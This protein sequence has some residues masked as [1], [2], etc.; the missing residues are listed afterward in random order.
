M[1][2]IVNKISEKHN[3]S[4]W[5]DGAIAE[6][7]HFIAVATGEIDLR[8]SGDNNF[9]C[10]GFKSY[11]E[12]CHKDNV[13]YDPAFSNDDDLVEPYYFD[14]NNWFEVFEKGDSNIGVVCGTYDEAIETL[15]EEE[16]NYENI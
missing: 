3:D 16:K 2:T 5:Y 7:E 8:R 9:R 4:F 6:T 10:N 14:M 12:T 15:L 1:K 13:I 11:D